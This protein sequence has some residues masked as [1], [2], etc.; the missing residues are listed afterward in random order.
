M[1]SNCKHLSNVRL[2][3]TK[4]NISQI[5]F[6]IGKKENVKKDCLANE[7][8]RGSISPPERSKMITKTQKVLDYLLSGKSITSWDAIQKFRATR[9]SAIIFNLKEKGYPIK[10]SMVYDID[11]DGNPV[12]YAK[13]W[14]VMQND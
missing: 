11:K 14:M 12:K 5:Q 8:T 7:R 4:E 9:L 1:N 10:S 2:S 13:Y 6:H 3:E